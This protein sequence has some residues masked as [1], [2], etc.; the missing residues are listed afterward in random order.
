MF[1]P[2]LM[3]NKDGTGFNP[4][5]D[6]HSYILEKQILHLYIP[7]KRRC[8]FYICNWRN[9]QNA[10]LCLVVQCFG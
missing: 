7:I 9:G 4:E 5:I 1:V 2:C 8:Q 3:G 10:F 6:P